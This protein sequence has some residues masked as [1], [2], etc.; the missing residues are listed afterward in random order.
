MAAAASEVFDDPVVMEYNDLHHNVQGINNEGI[1]EESVSELDSS[2]DII[3]S[4]GYSDSSE[5]SD[6]VYAKINDNEQVIFFKL[7]FTNGG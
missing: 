7:L 5:S 1:D 2:D 3:N 4:D 6:D